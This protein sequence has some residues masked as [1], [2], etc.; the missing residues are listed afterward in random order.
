MSYTKA[1]IYN[2]ALGALLLQRQISDPDSD[3]G[4]EVEVLNTHWEAALESTLADL[5][6]D[7]HST[8]VTLSLIET[9]PVDEWAYAYTYP[10][11]SVF[12]RRLKSIALKDNKTTRIP[13]K[14]TLHG[15]VKAI[16]TNKIEAEAEIIPNDLPISS[17][18]SDTVLAIAYRLAVLSAPLIVGKGA[19]TLRTQI[20]KNYIVSKGEAQAR[21]RQENFNFDDDS[22][23]SEFVEKRLE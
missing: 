22:V 11:V 15:G 17:F 6:L 20:E 13:L 12:L 9:D 23:D 4:N 21:D 19:K 14:I 5:D 1:K 3:T 7:S 10:A 2:L 8:F 18:S 16:F